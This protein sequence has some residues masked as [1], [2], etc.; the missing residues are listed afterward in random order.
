MLATN[1]YEVE[2]INK[3][4]LNYLGYSSLDDF[5]KAN[6]HLEDFFLEIKGVSF[7]GEERRNWLQNIINN[8]DRDI[9]V[10]FKNKKNP[11]GNPDICLVACNRFPEIDKYFFTFTDITRIEEEKQNLG[12]QVIT[13]ILTGVFNRKKLLD[14][15]AAEISRNVRYHTPL[16]LIMFD[17]DHFKEINDTYGHWTG[18]QVLKDITRTV[19]EHIRNIDTLAR[20]GGDEFLILAP[21]TDIEKAKQLADKLN[22]NIKKFQFVECGNVTCSFGVAQ[23][24]QN[25]DIENLIKRVDSAL[26]KAKSSGRDTVVLTPD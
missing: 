5:K 18:D 9:L 13:D 6:V 16:S 8:H 10:C 14:A 3:T 11:E 23:F 24:N 7:S 22:S 15:L 25:E 19:S 26:Y 17:I 2:Y 20:W 12:K 4:F 1:N 21:E